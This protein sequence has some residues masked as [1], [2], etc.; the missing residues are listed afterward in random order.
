EVA[1]VHRREDGQMKT[2]PME[3]PVPINAPPKLP[4]GIVLEKPPFVPRMVMTDE[5]LTVTRE[6]VSQWHNREKFAGLIKYG[7]RPLD[8]LL[9]YGP[10]GNGK[11]MACYWIA[12]QLGIP[13][14]RVLC[15]NLHG[16]SLGMT[17][18]AVA[19]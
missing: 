17:C 5:L 10:P 4:E 18:K 7:I 12:R 2:L 14:Y 19:D 15:N 16:S 6:V 13:V 1:H 11:T 8:R 9:F 3:K